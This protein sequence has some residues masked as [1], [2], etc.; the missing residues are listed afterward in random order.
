[1]AIKA[2]KENNII[3]QGNDNIKIKYA[4]INQVPVNNTYPKLKSK[5]NISFTSYHG[6]DFY[7]TLE[8]RDS[9]AYKVQLTPIKVDKIM[10]QAET[11]DEGLVKVYKALVEE[12]THINKAFSA[13]SLI[14]QQYLFV[15]GNRIE[16]IAKAHPKGSRTPF[17][18]IVAQGWSKLTGA[19]KD[20]ITSY[21]ENLIDDYNGIADTHFHKG[22]NYMVEDYLKTSKYVQNGIKYV[23]TRMGHS[24]L[25]NELLDR[26]TKSHEKYFT[27]YSE[28]G[29]NLKKLGDDLSKATRKSLSNQNK[30]QNENLAKKVVIK[31][32]TLGT[33]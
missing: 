12:S 13:F 18:G 14:T 32:I 28:L 5:S 23:N 1:M 6:V 30:K 27:L 10:K 31:I 4:K 29:A 8:L 9:L 22:I 11:T 16:D 33:A 15:A 26:L 2:T 20:R 17:V 19:F 21:S 7:G 24:S 25:R 3:F